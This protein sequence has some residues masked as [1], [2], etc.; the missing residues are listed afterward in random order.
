MNYLVNL[1]LRACLTFV[2]RADEQHVADLQA[3][4]SMP[5][6]PMEFKSA[7]ARL[8][9]AKAKLARSRSARDAL[10]PVGIRR[11]YTHA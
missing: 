2:V 8:A 5:L 4:L 6:S 11:T 10:L 9:D 3:L 7:L 1:I